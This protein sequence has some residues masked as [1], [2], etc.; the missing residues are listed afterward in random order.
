VYVEARDLSVLLRDWNTSQEKRLW[1][2]SSNYEVFSRTR[3]FMRLGEAQQQ[4][5]ETAGFAPDM[6][7]V[8][9]IAGGQSAAAVYDIGELEFL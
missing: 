5:A 6:S 7:L 9:S 3:L 2:A 1:L 8:N 4:F